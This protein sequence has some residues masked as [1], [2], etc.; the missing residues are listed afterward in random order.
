MQWFLLLSKWSN[1]P[2]ANKYFWAQI[3]V[4]RNG[5]MVQWFEYFNMV[6]F[7]N[8]EMIFIYFSKI[9]WGDYP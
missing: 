4:G 8:G 1:G 9:S 3:M 7:W 2:M 5:D 6:W